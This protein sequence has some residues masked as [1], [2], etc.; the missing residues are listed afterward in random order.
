MSTRLLKK[1]LFG[2]VSLTELNGKPVI[3]RDCSGAPAWIR[4]LARWMLGRE[5]A[6]LAL[7]EDVEGV[8]KLISADK[9][10]LTRSYIA[11]E[12]LY[13]ARTRDPAYY[14]DV[15]RLVRRIHKAGV[16]HNDLAKEPNL[17]VDEH[18]RPALIDFQI[19]AFPRRRHRLFRIMGR[20]DIRHILKHKRTYCAEHLTQREK[21]IL[22][23]P[24]FLSRLYR[25]TVKPVYMLVTRRILGWADREGA[26]RSKA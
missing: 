17:L 21:Q 11:G 23:T 14:A 9:G 7:L 20:E 16:V 12:P 4:W 24:S 10:R 15:M 2:N 5:S 25:R 1:D 18:G 3:V 26:E 19:A 13:R 6:A 22:Q 8:P